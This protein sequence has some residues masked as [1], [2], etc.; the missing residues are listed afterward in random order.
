MKF[1]I[2][3]LGCKVN[4]FEA[5]TTARAMEERGWSRN[6]EQEPVDAVLIFTC[7]VTNTAA[8][9][10]RKALYQYRRRYPKAVMVMAGCYVQVDSP[11]I[12]GADLLVGS[13][14]YMQI[15]DLIEQYQKDFTARIVVQPLAELT[16]AKAGPDVFTEQTR[17]YLKIQDGCNQCCSYCII[18]LARGHER[19]MPFREAVRQAA[20]LSVHHREIVLTGIHTG[21]YG[22]G[23]GFTLADL[24]ERILEE[25]DIRRL[26]IS[27]IEM[28]EIDARLIGLLQNPRLGRH[29]HIPV[30]AGNDRVLAAMKRPYQTASYLR[31][32]E[33]IRAA[34][35]D[36]SISTDLIVGFPGETEA[37]FRETMDFID[38]C[39]FSFLHVFPFSRRK[40][41]KADTMK[42]QVD[43]D[44]KKERVRLAMEKSEVLYDAFKRRLIGKTCMVLME[45]A[46]EMDTP[47][48]TSEYAE[49]QVSGIW[50]RGELFPV[51]IRRLENH[52]LF[53]EVEVAE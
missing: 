1:V 8:A 42:E 48:H 20:R 40:G 44:V 9:K 4:Q 5:Q 31:K 34:A 38:R 47:G 19:S 29:L 39:A 52:Q 12:V 46:G 28:N 3:S 17:A 15:P 43:E 41:T 21:R 10:S 49:V 25:T 22:Y 33:E 24:I 23:T 45:K 27:S 14:L 13:S 30:Q 26:R 36:I 32:L 6:V 51:R 18:P 53:G 50:K 2:F 37:Q 11:A 7:C 16:F 35:P